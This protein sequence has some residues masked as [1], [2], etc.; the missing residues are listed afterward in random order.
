MLSCEHIY[1]FVC[2]SPF[3]KNE[4]I[5]KN[6]YTPEGNPA[7]ECFSKGWVYFPKAGQGEWHTPWHICNECLNS[8][9]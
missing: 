2:D 3:C 1:T 6:S 5:I 9:K 7:I 4:L 8:L